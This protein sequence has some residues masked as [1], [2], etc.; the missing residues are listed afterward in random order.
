MPSP[1]FEVGLT[2]NVQL[3]VMLEFGSAQPHCFEN[4]NELYSGKRD[5][6]RLFFSTVGAARED[7]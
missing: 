3:R 4:S 1:S 7:F 2:R 6:H 5:T